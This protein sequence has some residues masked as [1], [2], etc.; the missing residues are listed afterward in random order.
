MSHTPLVSIV[1]VVFNGSDTLEQTI[2]SVLNQTYEN[3]EYIII[4]GGSTDGTLD[5]IKKYEKYISYWKSEPD[6]G[7]YDAMNKGVTLATGELIGMIN[8]DD[9]YELD[10]VEIM[11]NA[12]L[13]NP[14]K[15]LFH[16]DRYDVYPDGNKKVYK[17]NPSVFKLLY[18]GMTYNHPSM[19]ITRSEY[20][21]HLYDTNF[22]VFSD[23]MFILETFLRDRETIHYVENPIVNFRLGGVS[24]SLMLIGDFREGLK[25]RKKLNFNLSK[26]LLYTAVFFLA[27]TILFFKNK[28]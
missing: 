17:Y 21:H 5:I 26:R 6:N 22:K 2:K 1:T 15:S 23:Y 3:I 27:R 20:H 16:A 28:L 18:Y 4:D 19:F 9:W 12:Y 24:S 10:A 25:M 11:V 14:Q 7:L 8:S 13:Q